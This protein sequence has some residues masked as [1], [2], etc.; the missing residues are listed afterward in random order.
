MLSD[1]SVRQCAFGDDLLL[2]PTTCVVW[3]TLGD[4]MLLTPFVGARRC[5]PSVDLLLLLCVILRA[6]AYW[7]NFWLL[8]CMLLLVCMGF[9]CYGFDLRFLILCIEGILGLVGC[10]CSILMAVCHGM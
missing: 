4:G 9:G 5:A 10:G 8:K 1:A 7:L 6:C 2:L 3:C